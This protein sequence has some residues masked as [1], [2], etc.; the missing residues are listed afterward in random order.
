M[1]RTKDGHYFQYYD[2]ASVRY[3]SKGYVRFRLKKELTEE[4]L[5]AF[6]KSFYD[7]V[8]EAEAKSGSKV[9]NQEPLLK[10]LEK[11]ETKEFYLEMDCARNELRVPPADNNSQV[12]FTIVDQIESGTAMAKIRD[13]VC[14]KD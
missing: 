4:G 2:P 1:G 8:K 6:R 7:S 12:H 13:E 11:R 10:A 14:R 3:L 5:V 9:E